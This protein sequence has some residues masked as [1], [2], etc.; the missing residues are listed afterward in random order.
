V[1]RFEQVRANLRKAYEASRETVRAARVAEAEADIEEELALPE[2]EL[3]P[4][5]PP[6]PPPQ[7]PLSIDEAVPRGL[8]IAAAWS[9]RLIVVGA[10]VYALLWIAGHYMLLVAPLLVALLLAGLLMPA[11]RALLRIGLHRSLGALL[12]VVAGLGVVGGTLTLVINQFIEGLDD[13]VEQVERGIAQIQEWLETGPF[14]LPEDAL[15]NLVS[16][17]ADWVED[18]TRELTQAGLAAVTGAVQFLTGVI[19]AIV[20]TFFFL[21]DGGRIWRFLVGL[22]PPKAREPMAFAG[23]GA[24]KSLSGYVRATVLVALVD[25]VGI[26]LGLWI[27]SEIMNYPRGLVLPLAALV[28]LG[29]FVPIVGAFVSGTVAVLIGLVSGETPA[30]GLLQALIVFGI[31]LLVQQLESN[32]LQPFIVSKMVRVHP[33]AVLIAVLA[34]ILL[35]GIIGALVA[36]PIV[37]VI[38]T[39]I[40]RLHAYH[41]RQPGGPGSS[42]SPRAGA[43]PPDAPAGDAQPRPASPGTASPGAAS[44]GAASPGAEPADSGPPGSAEIGSTEIDLGQVGSAPSGSPSDGA[45][46]PGPAPSGSTPRPSPR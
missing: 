46:P 11:Q 15:E 14:G 1:G 19:F 17:V 44:P 39:V 30:Q 43:P 40:R 12:V 24:W 29:G 32:V 38:N 33:L 34:G 5:P 36:V 3:P 2:V 28:F 13:M 37:A 25:A 8:R 10:V 6:P 45:G 20:V 31:V 26:G 22:L 23:D 4:G 9:W 18:N 7:P 35:A 27:L 21:R 42:D 41:H 16:E